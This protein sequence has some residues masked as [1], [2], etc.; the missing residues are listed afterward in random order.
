M[1]ED[2]IVALATPPGESGIAIIR[3]SGKEA[4]RIA[5]NLFQPYYG[6]IM[7]EVPSHKLTL[8]WLLEDK[9]PLDQILC[10]I[11]Y[12]PHSYTGEDTAE[13]HCH[14]GMYV[15]HSCLRLCQQAGARMAM[16]GEFTQRAFLNGRIDLS[17]AEAIANIIN[18]Q[19]KK[20]LQIAA[21]QLKGQLRDLINAMEE[22]F[23]AMDAL[24]IASMDFPDDVGD[25]DRMSIRESL[26]AIKQKLDRWLEAAGR[27]EIYRTGIRLV[28]CGKPNVGK[29]SLLN[30]LIQKDKAIVTDIPGTTRDIIEDFINIA[31]I[32]VKIID[33]AGLRETDDVVEKIG[34]SKTKTAVETADIVLFM[35]D[36]TTGATVGDWQAYAEI[37]GKA[38]IILV[39]NK[40]DADHTVDFAETAKQF[41]LPEWVSISIQ[42]DLGI[43]DLQELIYSQALG[44]ATR[45]EEMAVM[46]NLR[47]RDAME[48][49]RQQVENLLATVDTETL[50]CLS[51]DVQNALD[52]L[53][54]ISGKSLAEDILDRIFRDFC[55]GK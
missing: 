5:G 18:A 17:Q 55:I 35:L 38:P 30:C 16:P 9:E 10:V 43:G 2:T 7:S 3:L 27:N 32:P 45:Q 39:Y 29:S 11:M 8:G 37:R 6:Q 33:T 1:L 21:G 44:S 14:G 23:I 49:C 24:I 50:D 52:A 36:V 25:V 40:I 41:S 53:G 22:D 28:I 20:G 13:F 31:G 15:V 46:V 42:N 51:I 26:I 12:G 47:Q 4:V 34:V 54:E 48:R 19:S